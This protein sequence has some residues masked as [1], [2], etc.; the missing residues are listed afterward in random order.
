MTLYY[1]Q[2][3]LNYLR[4]KLKSQ[5]LLVH[6]LTAVDFAIFLWQNER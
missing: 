4:N 1:Q 6:Q 2:L 5:E 3:T